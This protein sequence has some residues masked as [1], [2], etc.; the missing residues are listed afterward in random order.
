VSERFALHGCFR[1][2]EGQGDALAAV[3]LEAA[4]ALEGNEECRLYLV[5]R[6]PDDADIVWVTEVWTSREAHAASLEDEAVRALVARG[7][8]LIAGMPESR[9]LR[10]AGGKG[11]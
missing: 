8:P 9:E 6:S 3:L 7:M 1:A 11:L 4:D 2:H 10:P 5:S